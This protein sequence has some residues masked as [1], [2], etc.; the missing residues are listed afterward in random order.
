MWYFN[1]AAVHS[2]FRVNNLLC[3]AL[4]CKIF[5]ILNVLKKKYIFKFLDRVHIN[6]EN[7]LKKNNHF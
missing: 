6:I 1:N 7:N 3:F 2:T 4:P 5:N